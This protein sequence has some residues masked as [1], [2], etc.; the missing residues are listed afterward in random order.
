[1]NPCFQVHQKN[2]AILPTD[3]NPVRLRPA[4]P[5]TRHQP[6]VRHA[7]WATADLDCPFGLG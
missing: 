7:V 5:K 6:L 4:Q 3:I 2:N 1:M